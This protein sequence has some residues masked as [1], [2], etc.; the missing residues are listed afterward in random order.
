M[1]PDYK[2]PYYFIHNVNMEG[3]IKQVFRGSMGR[4]PSAQST[5]PTDSG[6]IDFQTIS[7]TSE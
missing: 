1:R 7:T 2:R 3:N 4:I 6:N 5:V